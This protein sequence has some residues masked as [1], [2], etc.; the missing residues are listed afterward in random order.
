MEKKTR[1]ILNGALLLLSAFGLYNVYGDNTEVVQQAKE[2]VCED[3]E[4]HLMQMSRTPIGQTF[5]FQT[6]GSSPLTVRCQR[7]LLLLGSYSCQNQ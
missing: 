6:E 3:C 1:L 7:A 2:L 4:P 5:I